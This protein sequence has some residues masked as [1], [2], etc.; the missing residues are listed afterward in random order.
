M[1]YKST[2]ILNTK[3]LLVIHDLL[4]FV[5]RCVNVKFALRFVRDLSLIV[6][7]YFGIRL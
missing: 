4:N 6:H 7:S 3:I 5:K 2:C 1:H